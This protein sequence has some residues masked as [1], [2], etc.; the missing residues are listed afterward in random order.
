MKL[1]LVIAALWGTWAVEAQASQRESLPA[2]LTT[3][4]D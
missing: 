3:A 2:S 1:P 4:I